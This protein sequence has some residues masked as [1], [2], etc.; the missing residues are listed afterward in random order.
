MRTNPE[1]KGQ[2]SHGFIFLQMITL[3]PE[4]GR[5]EAKWRSTSMASSWEGGKKVFERKTILPSPG[6][7]QSDAERQ[8]IANHKRTSIEDVKTSGVLPKVV[9]PPMDVAHCEDWVKSCCAKLGAE[10]C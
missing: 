6:P 1:S 3:L 5:P 10:F 4:Q 2:R 7:L 9:F 8:R